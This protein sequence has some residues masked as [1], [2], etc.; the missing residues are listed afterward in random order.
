M[1]MPLSDISDQ[2]HV[3]TFIEAPSKTRGKGTIRPRL[4]A[5]S[6][7]PVVTALKPT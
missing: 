2:C 6:S 5:K 7:Y 1:L 4:S 3:T